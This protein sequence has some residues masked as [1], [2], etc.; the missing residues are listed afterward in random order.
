MADIN[1]VEFYLTNPSFRKWVKHPT[2]ELDEYWLKWVEANS[3]CQVYIKEAKEL[4]FS[5]HFKNYSINDIDK[6]TLLDRI[7]H[8]IHHASQVKILKRD[9][10]INLSYY[11][12][13]AA[14]FLIIIASISLVY[15]ISNTSA[16]PDISQVNYIIKSTTL[17]EKLTVKLQD[18]SLVKLNS[19]SGISY[20]EQFN[21]EERTIE[22]KGEAYFDV[23]KDPSR[24]FIVKAG[25]IYIKALGTSF[26]ISNY[27][28]DDSIFV[29]LTSGEV[30]VGKREFQE[31]INLEPGQ[32]ASYIIEKDML[33]RHN[34]LDKQSI[35]WMDDIIIFK[36]AEWEEIE[37]K[38]KRW[39]GVE[40]INE[41]PGVS[42]DYS[43]EFKGYSLENILKSMCYAKN[44]NFKIEKDMVRIF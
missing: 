9:F 18:G 16:K 30:L 20:P 32:M 33:V 10:S 5:V 39:Y 8:E 44:L 38:L 37:R 14:T 11:L 28:G 12:K 22:L 31:S 26:S 2:K 43:G 23:A 40:I 6:K 1:S 29:S 25:N 13:I 27:S 3:D 19:G 34:F 41:K 42:W 21:V 4:L 17:G 36:N 15:Q 24:A 7:N 35:S